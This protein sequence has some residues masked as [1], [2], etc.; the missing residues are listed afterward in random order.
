MKNS[1]IIKE[2]CPLCGKG[3]LKL[4]SPQAHRKNSQ[5]K[6][7]TPCEAWVNPDNE[8]WIQGEFK[9]Y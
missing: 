6:Y 3:G 4:F 5:V 1:L 9:L 8:T 7:C 2:I